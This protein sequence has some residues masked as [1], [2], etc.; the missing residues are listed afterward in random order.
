MSKNKI[1]KLKNTRLGSILALTAFSAVFLIGMAAM[2]TD[3]GT[4]YYNQAR[5]Q[6]AVNAGWKAGFDK[7]MALENASNKPLT[8]QEKSIVRQ[9]VLDVM[10]ANGYTDAELVNV[11]IN[12]ANNRRLSVVSHQNVGLFFARIMNFTSADVA[13]ARANHADDDGASVIP[14]AIPNGVVK[15]LSKNYFS[16]DL[17]S[18][19]QGFASGSE[20]ILKLGSGGSDSNLPPDNPDYKAILVPMGAGDQSTNG[21]L[22]AYGVAFWCLKIDDSDTGAFTPVQWLLGYRGGSFML[23]YD[24]AVENKLNNYGVNYEVITGSANVQAIY[25]AVNPHILDLIKRP[26]IAVYSSQPGHDPVEEVLIAGRIPYGTYSLPPS[27][28]SNGWRRNQSYSSSKCNHIFDSEI[29]DGALDSY[30]W[31]HLHHEDFTGFSGGCDNFWYSCKDFYDKGWLGK[32]W[33]ESKRKKC[34]NKM[35]SYCRQYF[36][37]KYGSWKS[38]YD[39]RHDYYNGNARCHNAIRRCA[40]KYTYTGKP[41]RNDSSIYICRRGNTSYPQCWEY[42]TLREV[43]TA[44]GYTD[45]PGSEPKPQYYVNPWGTHPLPDNLPGYFDK[46]TMVQKMKWDVAKKIKQHVVDGGFLFAQCFA[47]ET[48]DISLWQSAIHDGVSPANAYANCMAFQN[49]HYKTFPRHYGAEWYS[50][51]NTRDGHDKF[52]LVLPLDP[53]CQNHGT[54]YCCDTGNGHTSSFIASKIKSN[55]TILGY[56]QN[57]GKQWVKYLKGTLGKGTFTFLGG[58]YHNSVYSKRLVLD[59]ILLGSLV[60]KEVTGGGGTPV[61]GG[62]RKNNYGPIDPDNKN[63]GGANDYRDRFKYGYSGSLELGDRI[64]PKHGNMVGP[65]D[66]AVDFKVNGDTTASPSRRVIIPITDV[67]PEIHDNSTQNASATC[68]YDL[69]GNDHPNGI[70]DPTKYGFKSS[71]RIIGFAEFEIEDPSEYTRKGT[72]V[73]AGDNGDLGDYQAGQVRG[74]FIRYIVKPGDVPVN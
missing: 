9:Q 16:L 39:P 73:Q 40:D 25:D 74:K 17:F 56:Q 48:L 67:G 61:A 53:R 62:R 69:Q 47:P 38:G 66:Q 55:C 43:A 20:Y 24:P 70:Y 64:T 2:V 35:C 14:L 11:A 4:M 13:A 12:I 18:G 52:N 60:T 54:G 72:N 30:H 50:D 34:W 23:P 19:S 15:D 21:Y 7:M 8:D 33:S 57:H 10:K 65:T 5:L 58:H 41:W 29:L 63:G 31:L 51:I 71:V 1:L 44:H 3:V 46:A 27:V 36:N 22:R 42:N 6:T 32:T 68:I 49:F 59:N 45:D 37:Y 28:N 26:R